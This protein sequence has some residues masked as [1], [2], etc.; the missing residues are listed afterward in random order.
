MKPILA[1][2]FYAANVILFVVLIPLTGNG[3]TQPPVNYLVCVPA[4]V[5]ESFTGLGCPCDGFLCYNEDC[6]GRGPDEV[7]VDGQCKDNDPFP[8]YCVEREGTPTKLTLYATFMSCSSLPCDPA[9]SI[10]CACYAD[11]DTQSIPEI[12][13]ATDCVSNVPRI[14]LPSLHAYNLHALYR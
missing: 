11:R 14:V 9:I 1:K 5:S 8:T 6:S 3:D 2:A 10:P 12:Y 13:M 4:Y 7:P